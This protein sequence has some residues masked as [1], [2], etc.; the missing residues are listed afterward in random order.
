MGLTA[1]FFHHIFDT[2]VQAEVSDPKPVLL[3]ASIT[4]PR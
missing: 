2:G 4:L 3:I 1:H